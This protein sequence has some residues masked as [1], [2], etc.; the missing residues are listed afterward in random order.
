MATLEIALAFFA[1]ISWCCQLGCQM[2]LE[3]ILL[4]YIVHDVETC[5]HHD[6]TA[7]IVL[8]AYIGAR[9]FH[10][11][12]WWSTPSYVLAHPWHKHTNLACM[13]FAF[14]PLPTRF[15]YSRG[16]S[17]GRQLRPLNKVALLPLAQADL[18]RQLTPSA[19][20]HWH[21]VLAKKWP[22][23]SNGNKPRLFFAGERDI[24]F[25]RSLS[26]AACIVYPWYP[27]VCFC[28]CAIG[29]KG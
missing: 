6:R 13:A 17:Y 29:V 11:C 24:D 16:K 10:I 9:D 1:R 27:V 26:P 8:T 5:I 18:V 20:Y 23:A 22:A 4:S 15:K 3:S 2:Y 25:L 21:Q 28:I 14:I 19:R 7:I 12:C